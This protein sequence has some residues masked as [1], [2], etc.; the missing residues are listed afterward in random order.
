MTRY[1]VLRPPIPGHTYAWDRAWVDP[2]G[3][4][5]GEPVLK[6]PFHHP[7]DPREPVKD[8][9]VMR[10]WAPEHLAGATPKRIDGAWMWVQEVVCA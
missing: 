4:L 9:P 7:A 10:I 1:A 5:S 3:M 2:N 6:V 8:W